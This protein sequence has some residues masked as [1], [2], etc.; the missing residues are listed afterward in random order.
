[1]QVQHKVKEEIIHFK[2]LE[3]YT[4]VLI[5]FILLNPVMDVITS[6][7]IREFGIS[8]SIGIAAKGLFLLYTLYTF[9][10]RRSLSA[11]DK[12]AKVLLILFLVYAVVHSI[13]STRN[14]GFS[15][16][17]T[18]SITMVKTFYLPFLVLSLNRLIEKKDVPYIIRM[19]VYGGI[20]V[21]SIMALSM[22]TDT[23]YNA[24]KYGKTG[25]VGWFFAANEVSA[26]LGIL[27]PILIYYVLEKTKL[28]SI[29][30]VLLLGIY[31]FLYYQ[32][33]TKVVALSVIMTLLYLILL[34]AVR[35]ARSRKT[36]I[37]K[38][39][40]TISLLL[41]LS[42]GLVPVTPIG[43]NLNLHNNLLIDQYKDNIDEENAESEEDI[44]EDF[45]IEGL[46]DNEEALMSLVFSG[47][48]EYFTVRKFIYDRAAPAEKLFGLT[49]FARTDKEEIKSYIIEIDYFDIFFNF[50]IIG[51]LFYWL[52]VLGSLGKSMKRIFRDWLVLKPG[53]PLPYYICSV[54][55]AFGIALFAGHVFVSPSVSFYLAVIIGILTAETKERSSHVSPG[56]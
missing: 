49:Q 51:S 39:L 17:I 2:L 11:S 22:L 24:Y 47:R 37:L 35:K 38:P 15:R 18:G 13:F 44:K 55:L 31:T 46:L 48:D 54:I 25:S 52:I 3:P 12:A 33:G 26:L 29:F 8:L 53:S 16:M 10:S 23:D 45:G 4:R 21:A 30:K 42:I 56:R 20:F 27:T 9:I 32:I 6:I 1:M 41:L 7:G 14:F 5:A 34:H 50:G 43:I 36:P 28:H 40:V 19:L